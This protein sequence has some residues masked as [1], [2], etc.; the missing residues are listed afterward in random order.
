MNHINNYLDANYQGSEL[1]NE[2]RNIRNAITD[3][4]DELKTLVAMGNHSAARVVRQE[5]E[6]I[7]KI[8]E[9]EYEVTD[10]NR[11]QFLLESNRPLTKMDTQGT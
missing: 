7:Q 9:P 8:L 3:C 5:M 11:W 1:T 4:R 6:Q 2:K 10:E